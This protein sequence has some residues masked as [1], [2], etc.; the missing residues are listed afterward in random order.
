MIRSQR[1]VQQG[2]P[3]GPSLFALAIH[4][5]VT[6]SARLTEARFPGDL[7]FHSFF[8]DDGVLAGRSS[9][10]QLLLSSLETSLRVIGLD[11]ARSKTEIVPACT[12]IQNFSPQ[13]FEGFL[14]VPHGNFKLLGA[15]IGSLEWCESL[16]QRRVTKAKKLLDAIGRYSMLK[17]LSLFFVLVADGPRFFIHVGRFLL[18]SNRKAFGRPIWISATP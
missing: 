5:S 16:L 1:G 17:V 6:G 4:P 14:W 12:S 13:D 18:H 15:A 8:L 7:D 9:A 2:D 3:L 11:I 10:V